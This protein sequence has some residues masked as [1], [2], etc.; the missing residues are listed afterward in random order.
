MI[1][2]HGHPLWLERT[3]EGAKVLSRASPA[4]EGS[5]RLTHGASTLLS[6]LVLLAERPKSDRNTER[7]TSLHFSRPDGGGAVAVGMPVARHP[8]HGSVREH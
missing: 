4:S 1:V 3:P 5:D 2:E 6:T 8:P 7:Y